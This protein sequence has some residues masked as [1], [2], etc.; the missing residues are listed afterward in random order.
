MVATG[1]TAQHSE[2]CGQCEEIGAIVWKMMV[3]LVLK[4]VSSGGEGFIGL[5][6]KLPGILEL[7]VA[8]QVCSGPVP[9]PPVEAQWVTESCD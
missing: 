9:W 8:W 2:P 6:M 1:V 7:P 4:I 5:A 3:D